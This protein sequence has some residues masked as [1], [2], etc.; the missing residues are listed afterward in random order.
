MIKIL[1]SAYLAL[2]IISVCIDAIFSK[3]SFNE[4]VL[5]TLNARIVCLHVSAVAFIGTIIR[6]EKA[7][8]FLREIFR[9]R[10]RDG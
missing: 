8:N 4:A 1:I 5:Y 7:I 2:F 9:I 10:G 6:P 3:K